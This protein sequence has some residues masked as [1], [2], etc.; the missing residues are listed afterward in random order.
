MVVIILLMLL[1]LDPFPYL[2]V[3]GFSNDHFATCAKK[4]ESIF[5]Y[6][7]C[8]YHTISISKVNLLDYTFFPT[9]NYFFD[10][11][12]LVHFLH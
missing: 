11:V 5:L 8:T 10:S 6:L 4:I 12:V 2:F 9:S 7:M 1:P 3:N